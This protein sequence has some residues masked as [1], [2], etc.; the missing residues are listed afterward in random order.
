MD[1]YKFNQDSENRPFS[2][3]RNEKFVRHFS[4]HSLNTLLF[5]NMEGTKMQNTSSVNTRRHLMSERQK[6]RSLKA[7]HK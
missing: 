6:Y 4:P 3:E 5:S 1:S 2:A 7:K